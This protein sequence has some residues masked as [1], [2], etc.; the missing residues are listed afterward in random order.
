MMLLC[1]AL[2]PESGLPTGPSKAPRDGMSTMWWRLLIAGAAVLIILCLGL[3][4]IAADRA[5]MSE[6]STAT[7]TSTDEPG[8]PWER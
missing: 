1:N 8:Q 2:R 3:L 5:S 4:E 7:V 6:H